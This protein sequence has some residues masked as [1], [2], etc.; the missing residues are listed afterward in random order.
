MIHGTMAEEMCYQG[1]PT[2]RRYQTCRRQTQR[3]TNETGKDG[4][5]YGNRTIYDLPRLVP[6]YHKFPTTIL[7]SQHSVTFDFILSLVNKMHAAC[8]SSPHNV[9]HS[10]S[11]R[12]MVCMYGSWR[13]VHKSSYSRHKRNKRVNYKDWHTHLI[14]MG[15]LCSL[16][17]LISPILQLW[18]RT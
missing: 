1:K 2:M 13:M 3:A 16:S 4:L 12:N 14:F 6:S 11:T 8:S 7:T 5:S 15:L 18:T 17:H 9:L 10:P